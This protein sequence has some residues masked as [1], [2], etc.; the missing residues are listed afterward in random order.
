MKGKLIVVEGVDGVGKNTQSKLLVQTIAA[1]AP[2]R[3]FSFPQYTSPTGMKVADYLNGRT[4]NLSRMDIAKLYADDRLAAKAEII[5]C[6]EKGIHVVC[7]RYV[8]SNIAF[9][10]SW[11]LSREN[12][13]ETEA[14]LAQNMIDA[15]D[16]LEYGENQMPFPDL[17]F[18]LIL[19]VDV[20][21]SRVT[22]KPKRDYTEAIQ[23]IHEAD[24][25]LQIHAANFYSTMA[26][27]GFNDVIETIDCWDSEKETQ[28]SEKE[29]HEKIWYPHVS[30]LIPEVRG[31]R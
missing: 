21:I 19:P 6:L 8:M 25:K 7:D 10:S 9:Q 24:L 12:A 27:I 1:F 20:T 15:I 14:E 26:D 3:F 17:T 16:L 5:E 28:L 18:S 23:D 29:I 4:P 22:G 11:Y 13:G 30:Y 2:V 31:N